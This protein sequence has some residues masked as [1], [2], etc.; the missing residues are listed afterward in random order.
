MSLCAEDRGREGTCPLPPSGRRAC[1]LVGCVRVVMIA[2]ARGIVRGTKVRKLPNGYTRSRLCLGGGAAGCSLGRLVR[3]SWRSGAV[4]H[5]RLGCHGRYITPSAYCSAARS[6]GRAPRTFTECDTL[7][8]VLEG[9]MRSL[10]TCG[11]SKEQSALLR[12]HTTRWHAHS[13][14]A[15]LRYLRHP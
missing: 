9:C 14:Y 2:Y 8:R 4:H 6:G 5:H 10:A 15:A 12:R 3:R 1:W 7:A 11:L 13:A